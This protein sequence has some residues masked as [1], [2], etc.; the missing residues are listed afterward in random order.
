M[1]DKDYIDHAIN[2]I[3]FLHK[4]DESYKI[5]KAAEEKEEELFQGSIQFLKN[6]SVGKD[7]Y[8]SDLKKRIF[9]LEKDLSELTIENDYQ[10][11]ISDKNEQISVMETTIT[12]AKQVIE[13]LLQSLKIEGYDFSQSGSATDEYRFYKMAIEILGEDNEIHN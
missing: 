7:E 12:Q 2:S 5:T 8:I 11:V 1:T 3:I 4:Y 9:E 13:Y 6:L 10:R